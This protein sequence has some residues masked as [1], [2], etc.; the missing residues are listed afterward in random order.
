VS[1][2]PWDEQIAIRVTPPAK[3]RR[4]QWPWE[5]PETIQRS[6]DFLREYICE[7]YLVRAFDETV[8]YI[9]GYGRGF[10]FISDNGVTFAVRASCLTP[11]SKSWVCNFGNTDADFI[12]FFGF[13]DREN[14]NLEFCLVIQRDR[15]RDRD[16]ITILDDGYHIKGYQEFWVDGEIFA[17]MQE[18]MNAIRSQDSTKLER[19]E[20]Q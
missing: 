7:V 3:P 4:P 19:Y 2:S 16:R 12:L 13:K 8:R 11:T 15:F 6:R 20:P 18:V 5:Q 1:N 9:R 17:K 14:P 10:N